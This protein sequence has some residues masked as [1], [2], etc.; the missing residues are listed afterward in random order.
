MDLIASFPQY[1]SDV[2]IMTVKLAYPLWVSFKSIKSTGSSDDTTWLIYW[3]V[4]AVESFIEAYVLPFVA[5]VPFFMLLRLLF[6]IWLQL[7][8]FNGSILIFNKYVRPF[9]EKHKSE[10]NAVTSTDSE[11]AEI[12][13]KQVQREIS[14]AY[15]EILEAIE[16]DK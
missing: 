5:W 4:V 14:A 13:K 15:K 3:V 16:K 10:L 2:L 7:P 11:E 6:Y 1:A 9:F 8:V 12:V